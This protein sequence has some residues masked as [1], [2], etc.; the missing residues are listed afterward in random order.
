[1]VEVV[2]RV[3]QKFKNPAEYDNITLRCSYCAIKVS[4]IV[5]RSA[6]YDGEQLFISPDGSAYGTIKT[7]NKFEF[8]TE[9]P[10]LGLCKSVIFNRD[11][12]FS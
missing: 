4:E 10:L 3:R 2:V 6:I 12:S 1:M 8:V 11:L 5:N 7:S 9:H